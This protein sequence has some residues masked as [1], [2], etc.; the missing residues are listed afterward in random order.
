M[1]LAFSRLTVTVQDMLMAS[2]AAAAAVIVAANS[3]MLTGFVS[4]CDIRE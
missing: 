4:A 1:V 2:H 3:Y